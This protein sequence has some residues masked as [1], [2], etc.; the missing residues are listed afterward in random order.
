MRVVSLLLGEVFCSVPTSQV[1]HWTPVR[2]ERGGTKGTNWPKDSG[3][4]YRG[5]YR[6]HINFR[7]PGYFRRPAHEN[8]EVIFVGLVTD[9]NVEYFRGPG[10][11]FVGS[12]TKIRKLFSSA[13]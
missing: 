13:S 4:A 9:E 11:I 12:S 8:T 7:G 2:A 6:K 5:H 1:R 3:P 10:N